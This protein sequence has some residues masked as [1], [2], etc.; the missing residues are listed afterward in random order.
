[1][2]P[3]TGNEGWMPVFVVVP[4]VRVVS[5]SAD[6]PKQR[7]TETGGEDYLQ[8]VGTATTRGDGTISIELFSVP[9]N[10]KLLL[11]QPAAGEK[12]YPWKGQ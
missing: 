10:G 7:P 5:V 8:R 2:K 3:S 6:D 12:P 4:G 9:L 11:R 1:M